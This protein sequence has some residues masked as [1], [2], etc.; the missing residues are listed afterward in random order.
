MKGFSV[1]NF[2]KGNKEPQPKPSDEEAKDPL[3]QKSS[4]Q[5]ATQSNIPYDPK[6]YPPNIQQSEQHAI[7]RRVSF[8]SHLFDRMTCGKSHSGP[9]DV[10]DCCGYPVENR[11]I[12]ICCT[13]KD[14]LFLGSGFPLFFEFMKYGIGML[15]MIMLIAGLYNISTNIDSNDCSTGLEIH[16][17]PCVHDYFTDTSLVNKALHN[18]Y[19]HA[20]EILNLISVLFCIFF[21]HV[22]RYKQ[23][24]LAFECD[25]SIVTASDYTLQIGNLPENLEEEKLVTFIESLPTKNDEPIKVL[26]YF[27]HSYL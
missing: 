11:L 21:M 17:K 20:Q 25:L 2:L 24:K 7:A 6:L 12:P 1:F 26:F 13:N 19:L 5:P 27:F 14:L 18:D 15:F 22:L 16:D 10:C 8:P 4:D 9:I 23:R 3:I